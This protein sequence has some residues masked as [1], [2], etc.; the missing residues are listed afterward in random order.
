MGGDIDNGGRGGAGPAHVL[1]A[2]GIGAVGGR[3]PRTPVS[4]VRARG[5]FWQRQILDSAVA[6]GMQP[7]GWAIDPRDWKRPAPDVILANVEKHLHHGA[8]ILL[9]DGGGSRARTV[10]ALDR[11]LPWLRSQGY[12]TDFP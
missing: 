6:Q 9:H 4:N 2:P 3:V 11:L 7:L 1:S 8:V 5:G 12:V 10:E